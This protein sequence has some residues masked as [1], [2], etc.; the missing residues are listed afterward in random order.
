VLHQLSTKCC[1]C[2]NLVFCCSNNT[3]I[4]HKVCAKLKYQ[5]G[6][7]KVNQMYYSLIPN[8]K[9][10]SSRSHA[11]HQTKVAAFN[12]LPYTTLIEIP[13]FGSSHRYLILAPSGFNWNTSRTGQYITAD[14]MLNCIAPPLLH[15]SSRTLTELPLQLDSTS[16]FTKCSTVHYP[17][18]RIT[19][20]K[21]YLN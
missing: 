19:D 1:L 12:G 18:L 16:L 14:Q 7:L 8:R 9:W 21:P 3:H 20:P 13:V 15:H 11:Y 5:P 17:H 4:F 10:L 6:R 2:Y